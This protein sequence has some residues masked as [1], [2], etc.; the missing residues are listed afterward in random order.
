MMRS[1]WTA[2]S[3]MI[4]QQFNV[5]VIANNLANVNTTA[6]KKQRSEF[7]DLLYETMQRAYI[8]EDAGRPVN[9]QV[10]HGVEVVATGRDFTKGSF[11]KTD[12]KLDF[13]IDG[14]A[15]F[16]VLDPRGEVVYTRDG[17]FKI[18]MTDYGKMLATA[19][20]YPVLDEFGL[21]IYLDD[22]DIEKL[23][24]AENGELSYI[25]EDGVAVPLGFS[26]GLVK[27]ENR[28]GLE[29]IGRNL[30]A[31]TPASGMPIPDSE[32][33]QPS[34][35][36]QGFLETSNVQVVEEMVKLIA[37]QRAYELNSK[38]IQT[39]DEMISIANNLKR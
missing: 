8:L 34:I 9:L 14:N 36:R 3:G 6:Y 30:Y 27:F 38:A 24:V 37:A 26:I 19:E 4:A 18:S 35:L 39:S 7:K 1:M 5:D 21:E 25:D 2:G 13:A 15:F 28:E 23:I 10:G 32:M 11:E 31:M 33:G 16:C 17:S 20:G 12:N 29:N 22:I